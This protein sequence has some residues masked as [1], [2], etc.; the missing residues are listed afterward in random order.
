M[1]MITPPAIETG[2]IDGIDRE[3]AREIETGTGTGTSIRR[4]TGMVTSGDGMSGM[5]DEEMA[6]SVLTVIT[7]L[8][9]GLDLPHLEIRIIRAPSR[10]RRRSCH[11]APFLQAALQRS[12]Q[13][14]HLDLNPRR[15]SND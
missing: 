2:T 10:P 3:I 11:P 4:T 12:P 15:R 13:L 1:M 5:I 8:H 7:K 6:E 14:V 9:V